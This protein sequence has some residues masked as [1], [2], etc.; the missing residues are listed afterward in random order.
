MSVKEAYRIVKEKDKYDSFNPISAGENQEHIVFNN[1][2]NVV[3]G[4]DKRTGKYVEFYFLDYP[5]HTD[6]IIKNYSKEEFM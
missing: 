5:Y 2:D 4:V 6:D 1:Q 3:R